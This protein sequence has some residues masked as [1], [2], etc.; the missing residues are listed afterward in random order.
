[1]QAVPSR[2]AMAG[3]IRRNPNRET[4]SRPIVW[5]AAATLLLA[6]FRALG[7]ST[8]DNEGL[9]IG[10]HAPTFT[11][12]DQ[13]NKEVSLEALLKKGPVA[14]VFHRSV[15]WCMYCKL[16]MIQL[17]HIQKEIQAVGGQVVGISYDSVD[18]LKSY[19]NRHKINFPLLSDVGSKTIDAYDIRSKEAPPEISGFARHATFIVDQRGIIRSKIFRLSYQERPAVD[20]LINAL[21]QARNPKEEPKS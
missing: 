7:E 6:T 10:Q 5:L 16:Q 4:A 13:N 15:D 8:P 14:L 19:A 2:T 11:L 3:Q 21:T 20:L 18:K 17:E 9:P 12:R 1:M